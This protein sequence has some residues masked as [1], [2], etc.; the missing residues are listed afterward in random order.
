VDFRVGWLFNDRRGSDRKNYR[1]VKTENDKGTEGGQYSIGGRKRGWKGV[2][3][4]QKV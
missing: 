2:G 3:Q 1:T 4:G